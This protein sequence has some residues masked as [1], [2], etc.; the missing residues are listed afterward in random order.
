MRRISIFYCFFLLVF[1]GNK[2]IYS[3]SGKVPPF[4]IVQTNNKVFQAS[5]LPMGKHIIIYY[6]SPECEECENVTDELIRKIDVFNNASIVFITY[7]PLETVKT[8]ETQ[9]SL[10]KYSNIYVGTEGN[11]MFVANYY[12]QM[13]FPFIALYDKNG[14][15]IR[16]FNKAKNLDELI[17]KLKNL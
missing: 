7:F 15:L 14:N 17:H 6:F 10:S 2:N 16:K 13:E 12:R 11:S 8:F 1:I 4:K 5:G 3:Q 9:H